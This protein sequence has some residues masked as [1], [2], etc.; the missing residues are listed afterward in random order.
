MRV[1]NNCLFIVHCLVAAW[2][3]WL[4]KLRRSSVAIAPV[5]PSKPK[6]LRMLAAHIVSGSAGI[7]S[8]APWEAER[9]ACLLWFFSRF[10]L[11]ERA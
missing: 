7:C 8:A 11:Q 5:N 6:H 3:D 9:V 4:L 1:Q 2:Q 10:R